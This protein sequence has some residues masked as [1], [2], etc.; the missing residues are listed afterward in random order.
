MSTALVATTI[1]PRQQAGTALFA[2]VVLASLTEAIAGTL[3]SLSRGDI[4][5]DTYATPDEFAWLDV[6]YTTLKLIGFMAA[7]W[8]LTLINPRSLAIGATLVMGAAC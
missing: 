1:E 3:L 4:M 2:G 6:G 7:P 5:G 8:L